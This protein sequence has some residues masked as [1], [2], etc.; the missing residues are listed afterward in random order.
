MSKYRIKIETSENGA[1]SVRHAGNDQAYCENG[2]AVIVKNQPTAGWGLA[3]LYY[4]DSNNT[5]TKITGNAFT[6]P[7]KDITI[8]AE[9]KRFQLDDWKND[10]GSRPMT[11]LGSYT[12]GNL[13]ASA[14]VGDIAYDTSDDVYKYWN[15]DKWVVMGSRYPME[16]RTSIGHSGIVPNVLYML[17]EV[18]LLDITT[19]A[20]LETGKENTYHLI[21]KAGADFSLRVP[22]E[23]VWENNVFPQPNA[24]EYLRVDATVYNDSIVLA[25]YHIYYAS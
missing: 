16:V 15:G 25:S 1:V 19:S 2:E 20:T 3:D 23:W 17:G 11:T 21:M 8:H 22:G 24:N 5:K 10:N 9:F 14:S 6:M 7:S 18:G 4:T 12:T 13:P